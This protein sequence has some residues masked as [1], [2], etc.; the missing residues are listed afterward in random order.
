MVQI[1]PTLKSALQKSPA[2]PKIFKFSHTKS[3]KPKSKN[4]SGLEFQNRILGFSK[5]SGR[6]KFKIGFQE[7]GAWRCSSH[8]S[9]T[10]RHQ[11]FIGQSESCCRTLECWSRPEPISKIKVPNFSISNVLSLVCACACVRLHPKTILVAA[12]LKKWLRAYI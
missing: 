6:S 3:P 4:F 10:N 7:L 9:T 8:S 2:T 11:K 12:A 1:L 5:F